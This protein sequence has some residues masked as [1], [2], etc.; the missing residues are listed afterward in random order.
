MRKITN[1][2]VSVI[3]VM[4][5][6][7]SMFCGLAIPASAASASD[8]TYSI[9]GGDIAAGTKVITMEVTLTD[10]AGMT[11]GKFDLM[12]GKDVIDD[13]NF[14][15]DGNYVTPQ[16]ETLEEF[17]ARDTDGNFMI[18][19]VNY[20]K[21][22]TYQSPIYN[23]E[24]EL[25][26]YETKTR[27]VVDTDKS[28][29]ENNGNKGTLLPNVYDGK[30]GLYDTKIEITGGT[31]ASGTVVDASNV[32]SYFTNSE[33]DALAGTTTN[34]IVGE[35]TDGRQYAYNMT[36]NYKTAQDSKYNT[37]V[38]TVTADDGTESTR[39]VYEL[40]Q[41]LLDKYYREYTTVDVATAN[42]GY[43]ISTVS[44]DSVGQ[45]HSYAQYAQG[46]K[47]VTF[48]ASEA[49]SSITFTVTFDFSGTCDRIGANSS[50]D[51]GT[52]TGTTTVDDAEFNYRNAD[53]HWATENYV[54]YGTKYALNFVGDG[55]EAVAENSATNF[56]HVHD[57]I[58]DNGDGTDEPVNKAAI[59]AL[60]AKNPNAKEGVDYFELYN[61]K[62]QKCGRVTPMI[63]APDLPYYVDVYDEDGNKTGTRP[64]TTTKGRYAYNNFRNISGLSAIYEDDGTIALNIHYPSKMASEQMFITD[65]NG[66]VMK[67]SDT[68]EVYDD[69]TQKYTA[70][71][72]SEAASKLVVDEKEIARYGDGIISTAQMITVSGFSAAD[73]DKT[74][75]V[76]RYTPSS[77]TETQLM[78]IT[79]MISIRD[80]LNEVIKNEENSQED[81]LVAAALLN[82][83]NASTTALGTKKDEN[84]KI[85]PT[86]IDLLEF[87][88]YL[89]KAGSTSTYYDTNVAD[90][91]ETGASWDDPIIIDSAEE[92]VYIAKAATSDT[93][94]KYFKVADGIVGFDLS[95]G[96]I[97][98]Y[99]GTIA[100]QLANV[101]ASGKNHSGGT[102]GFQGHFDG[103]GVTVYGAWGSNKS[104]SAY[105][106]LFSCAKG[107]VTIKNVNVKL[108]S[109]TATT[110]AGGIVGYY[111]GEGTYSDHT[112]LTIENCSV[113]ESHIEITGGTGTNSATSGYGFGVGAIVGRVDAAPSYTDTNDEDGDNSTTDTVYVNNKIKINNCYVNLDK[114][115]F[116]SPAEDGDEATHG[117]ACHGGVVGFAGSN[118]LNASNCIVIGVTPYA[119]T[120]CTTQNDVQHSGLA[121]HFSNVYTDQAT[122]SIVIGGK[123]TWTGYTQNFTGKVYQL[124][125]DQLKGLTAADN[126]PNLNWETIWC[127]N[128]GD[129]PSLYAP[130]NIP[131]VEP[132]TIYWDGTTATGLTEGSGT[133]DDP[134]IIN[135]VA[136]LAYVVSQK[137]D[138]HTVTAGKYFKVADSV[139]GM[140]LQKETHAAVMELNSAAE[141]KAY[142][143]SA[144]GLL[145][146]KIGGWEG[147][148]FC[149]NIDFNGITIYGAYIKDSGSNAALF[150]NMDAGA[151]IHNLTLKNSYFTSAATNYQVAAIAAVSNSA[152]YANKMAGVTWIDSVTVA[153]NYLYNTSTQTNRSGVLVGSFSDTV[154]VD[155]CFVYGNDA[156]YGSGV[157]MPLI[158]NAGNSVPSTVAVPDGLVTKIDVTDGGNFHFNMV[159]N[160][161]V[162]GCDPYDVTQG[163]GSRFNDATAFENVYTD[164]ETTNVQFTNE[165]KTFTPAQL[166]RINA[167]EIVGLDAKS[168]M[169]LLGW[170]NALTNPDGA[171]YCS[172]IGMPSL[173]PFNET[174]ADISP[175]Y[176]TVYNS[177]AFTPDT[178]GDGIIYEDDGTMRF[179]VYATSI[180]LGS[181]PYMSFA[182]AFHGDY[183]TNRDD[184]KVRFTYTVNG[185]EY[186]VEGNAVP[187]AVDANGD[188]KID[189]IKNVNGWTNRFSAG[190]YH[191]YRFTDIPIFALNNDIVVEAKYGTDG[192]WLNFGTFSIGGLGYEFEQ[193]NAVTPDA[194]YTERA[195]AVKALM[196]YAYALEARYG[197][198]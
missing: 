1:K 126:M 164:A 79:H 117:R 122:G 24:G 120:E 172:Y 44:E 78:G 2:A 177:L 166:T 35:M 74:L 43:S 156:T 198:Q 193:S 25:T 160:S 132:K 171:W 60:L 146:W 128:E 162:L 80:Y 62:C 91:G 119:T 184:I 36:D 101:Q 52:L 28:Y 69:A 59:D 188:G 110:A 185:T 118:A 32:N 81:K 194:Y 115:N 104:I 125:D 3:L 82:Y 84:P 15:A 140:V 167:D 108:S 133:K 103:N 26:G 155:N 93:D 196:A 46:F 113:T 143:E 56:F 49:F 135:T 127:A 111:K 97:T 13:V 37:T 53:G 134:Y 50:E 163:T 112:T 39:T 98:D 23:D 33:Y 17:Y 34:A 168:T 114:D 157:K 170:N 142:F 19:G 40:S 76:A 90:N 73:I 31:L 77:D 190:R 139:S 183:K 136:E 70:I 86:E 63:A 189:D 38:I 130:Y 22:E 47:D 124:T 191:T 176:A 12:L 123:P 87:G 174:I 154:Y 16:N 21:E 51:A 27:T 5:I 181:K 137:P 100:E 161:I 42:L 45:T 178:Y 158:N 68:L 92:F 141:T 88:D 30:V 8:G 57:G 94:G 41:G 197:V 129:Y 7:V 159:R 180:N 151:S 105:S 95:G 144:S 131:E 145:Q 106:G 6:C 165:K 54:Q 65:E 83:A 150:C 89:T 147:S 67:Y 109:F 10:P 187:E 72:S 64:A 29:K 153:N 186:T 175:E 149:G 4:A 20:Y 173:T 107:D 182:F 169:P 75:Y 58:I 148:T 48:N 11:N 9:V 71:T 195:E 99:N 152:N 116:T 18:A 85:I 61:A 55:F 66:I 192:E 179:G 96:K 138:N 14:D 102:P 121:T